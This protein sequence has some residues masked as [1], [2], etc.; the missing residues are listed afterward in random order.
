MA[1]VI[2]QA[3]GFL[4]EEEEE[5]VCGICLE[6]YEDRVDTG[7]GHS[8][9][10]RC[11][12]AVL[13]RGSLG[14]R[15]PLC[16]EALLP[17]RR[18]ESGAP[19]ACPERGSIV[20]ASVGCVWRYSD[21]F[22]RGVGGYDLLTQ[23]CW[24][25]VDACFYHVGAEAHSVPPGEYLVAFRV[26]RLRHLRFRGP[27]V[28]Y[29]DG[30]EKRRVDLSQELAT[31]GDW[32]LLVVGT[33]DLDIKRDV[34]ASMR[35]LDQTTSKSGLVID[36][37]VLYPPHKPPPSIVLKPDD[38]RAWTVVPA[39]ARPEHLIRLRRGRWTIDR[40]RCR[41]RNTD[42]PSFVWPGTDVVYTLTTV[43]HHELVWHS[44]HPATFAE[45]RW[46]PR[47]PSISAADICPCVL[48]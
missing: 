2:S 6:A 11:V 24:L 1:R 28:L 25:V 9:C 23:D 39:N 8:Y 15:C 43:Q 37:L 34:S 3:A 47:P 4:E 22:A 12:E 7:C 19:V 10:K 46:R 14:A 44:D 27:V 29:L 13:Q 16:R 30:V 32:D 33:L 45:I 20:T 31:V 35:A 21:Q 18:H 5:E 40:Q 26:K 36:C 48:A 41:L 42:P 17:L 38:S